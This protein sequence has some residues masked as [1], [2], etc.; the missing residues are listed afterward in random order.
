MEIVYVQLGRSN[1]N[2][3]IPAIN[4]SLS[5]YPL[6]KHTLIV[7]DSNF[8]APKDTKINLVLN[9]TSELKSK[10]AGRNID[11]QFRMGYWNLTL[12]RIFA[13]LNYQIDNDLKQILHVE[14]DVILM[15]TFPFVTLEQ[16]GYAH[17]CEYGSGHDVAS[18]LHIPDSKGANQ[19]KEKMIEILS[20]NQNLTDMQLLY[21]IRNEESNVRLFPSF[22]DKNCINLP[23]SSETYCE[24]G[25]PNFIYD[26][27]TYGM[28]L[29]GQDPRNNYG[30]YSI[31][32]NSPFE[33]GATHINPKH[34][35]WF[36]DEL[37]RLNAKCSCCN[38]AV[39]LQNLHIHS[40]NMK[41][42]GGNWKTAL[43]K[44]VFIANKHERADFFDLRVLFEMLMNSFR[45]GNLGK[46]LANSPPIAAVKRF[47]LRFVKVK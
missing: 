27:L 19:I 2:Y 26:G 35:S 41:L 6:I 40:K 16:C 18:L 10:F 12:E 39:Q 7:D 20:Q 21:Q 32:D 44:L 43:A 15:E 33:S 3:L 30:R 5:I 25:P 8:V 11:Q 13:V 1:V 17:W 45:N 47:I 38:T 34:F 22:A 24:C 36:F 28:Y 37:G 23:K 29:S 31:G 46:F 4:R 9:E 42:F 14:S